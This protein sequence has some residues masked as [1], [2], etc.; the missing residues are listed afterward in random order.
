MKKK[1]FFIIGIIFLFDSMFF[2]AMQEKEVSNE[3]II[4]KSKVKKES[5]NNIK[6]DIGRSLELCHQQI[7][8]NIAK[9]AQVQQQVFDKI[10]DLVGACDGTE[11]SV[12]DTT[13]A[14][15]K[16]QR[17]QLKYFYEKLQRHEG[18]LGS[19][20]ACFEKC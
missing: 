10:K 3:F 1:L 12:F 17:H 5:V 16:E 4:T 13:L 18:E 11:K 6:E 2:C 14:Q 19:F 8:R 15:L 9:L 7:S 20:L